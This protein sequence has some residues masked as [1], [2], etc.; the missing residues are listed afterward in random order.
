MILTDQL[1][2]QIEEKQKLLSLTKFVSE[3]TRREENDDDVGPDCNENAERVVPRLFAHR[4]N[5]WWLVLLKLLKYWGRSVEVPTR[6]R[7]SFCW[8]VPSCWL[9]FWRY[10][11]TFYQLNEDFVI[12]D[13]ASSPWGKLP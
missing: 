10:G 9:V 6:D 11:C 12:D 13:K 1:S 3:C 7:S 5:R 2:C 8:R 4:R